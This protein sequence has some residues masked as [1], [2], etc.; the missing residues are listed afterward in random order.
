MPDQRDSRRS[1][2]GP[3]ED[4]APR[5]KALVAGIDFAKPLAE[6]DLGGAL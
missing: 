6:A 4:N 2:S 3:A 1:Q 5:T